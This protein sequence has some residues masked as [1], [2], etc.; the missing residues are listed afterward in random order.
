MHFAHET[1]SI[2]ITVQ[3]KEGD[4]FD[5]SMPVQSDYLKQSN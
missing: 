5:L 2:C 1:M 3:V 4:K